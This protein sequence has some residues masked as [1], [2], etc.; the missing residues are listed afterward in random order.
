MRIKLIIFSLFLF[1]CVKSGATDI[2]NSDTVSICIMGDIMMHQR[3]IDLARRADGSFDFS[4][5]FSH[6]ENRIKSSDLALANMEFTLAGEPHSGYPT[7]SA[8]DAY[9]EYIAKCGFDIFLAANNHIYDKGGKGAARTLEIY[10]ELGRKY[11]IKVCG[12]SEDETVMNQTTPLEVNVK[13]LK[14]GLINFT[15]G[16]NLGNDMHWPKTNYMGNKTLI[17]NAIKKAEDCDFTIALPHWGTEYELIH[18]ETQES[19][20]QWIADSGADAIIGTHPHVPQDFQTITNRQIPVAYSLGNAVSN[21]SAANTQIG[22]MAEIRLTREINGR[23]VLLPIK[24]TYL[25]CSRPGG[26]GSS[27]TVIPIKE[28]IDKKDLWKGVWDYEKMVSTYE[29]VRRTINIEDN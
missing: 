18:S 24:F 25:W 4:S 29:S 22:L 5:Y 2:C 27:Y 14:I 26:I 1:A 7:F 20:A 28:Y 15:Y 17:S 10:R 3:Q 21:M 19:V 6:I 8:P 11:G 12:L 9:A 16:T 23:I 13:G